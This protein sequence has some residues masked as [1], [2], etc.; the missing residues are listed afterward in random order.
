MNDKLQPEFRFS[1][2]PE[3]IIYS[4]LSDKA[5]RLYAVLARYADNQ[6]HE[7]FPS[8]ETLADKMGCSPSSVDRAATELVE[9]WGNYE[10]TTSQ[11]LTCL[12]FADDEGGSHQ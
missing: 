2:M 5:I 8:R 3:W 1:I 9:R 12:H 4:K 7:A 10:E 11:Q 6:T